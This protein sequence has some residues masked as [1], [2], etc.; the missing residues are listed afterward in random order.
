LT[1]DRAIVANNFEAAEKLRELG[2]SAAQKSRDGRLVKLAQRV[3]E[4]LQW[5]SEQVA[6]FEQAAAVREEKPQDPAACLTLGKFYCFVAGDWS[7]GLPFFAAVADEGLKLAAAKD[8][9][10]PNEPAKQAE[11]GDAWWD[12]VESAD[13][14]DKPALRDRAAHW[15]NLAVDQLTGLAQEKVQNRLASL[16]QAPAAATPA[17]ELPKFAKEFI[18]TYFLQATTKSKPAIL[19][20]LEFAENFDVTENNNVIAHWEVDEGTRIKVTFDESPEQPVFFKP[21]SSGG[22]ISATRSLQGDTWRWQLTRLFIVSVWEHKTEEPRFGRRERRETTETL[23]LYSNG[24][25]NDP[26]G[27]I[28]WTL[29]GRNL[30]IDWGDGK[31]TAATV[32][33][34][35]KTYA[36]KTSQPTGIGPIKIGLNVQG[37]LMGQ[38]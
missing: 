38:E 8:Q 37:S 34:T 26:L 15:Y 28:L 22:T 17:G 32:G 12:L 35:G 29:Q 24:R 36:G 2:E 4:E 3:D 19:T 33:P 20:I 1:V 11:A 31:K 25:V 9:A 10:E 16:E 7:R 6:Q 27:S 21:R 13:E 14:A 23:T 18:G 30:L 5:L